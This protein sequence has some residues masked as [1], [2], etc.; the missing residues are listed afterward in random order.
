MW[1]HCSTFRPRIRHLN[2]TDNLLHS[3]G[4]GSSYH[5]PL[6]IHVALHLIKWLKNS[7]WHDPHAATDSKTKNTTHLRWI[8]YFIGWYL[9]CAQTR[10]V[11]IR[12]CRKIHCMITLAVGVNSIVEFAHFLTN[13]ALR[14]MCFSIIQLSVTGDGGSECGKF[15]A[16]FLHM[17]YWEGLNLHLKWASLS[18]AIATF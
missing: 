5:W 16:V 13:I 6:R 14:C 15:V 3:E 2:K 18:H 9:F 1:I 8:L 4:P 12:V 7:S 11:W 10:R 17:A